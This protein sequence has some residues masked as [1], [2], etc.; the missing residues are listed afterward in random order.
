MSVWVE[1]DAVGA[2]GWSG[3]ASVTR[4]GLSGDPE[5]ERFRRG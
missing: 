4:W 1:K 3:I 5:P 2:H